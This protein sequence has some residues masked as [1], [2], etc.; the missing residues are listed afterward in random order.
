MA[1]EGWLSESQIRW[2]TPFLRPGVDTD[3]PTPKQLRSS[4]YVSPTR[5]VVMHVDDQG[6]LSSVCR[7][8]QLALPPD[9]VFSHLTAAAIRGWRMPNISTVPIVATTGALAPHHDRR[10]VFVRRCD[11][12]PHHRMTLGGVRVASPEWTIAELAEDLGLVDLVAVIDGALHTGETTVERLFNSIVPGRRG[13]KVLRDS[14]AY[15]DGLS[16][17]WW[18]SV[19][20][21]AHQ[22]A[23]IPIRS[24]V[25]VFNRIGT[26]V[27]RADLHIVGTARYP[28]YEGATHR[29]ALRHR[30]DLS[31]EKRLARMAFERYGY[32]ADELVKTPAM[33]IEDAEDALGW[34]HDTQRLKRWLYELD[35]SSISK[36]GW[37]RLQR[38]LARFG[39][40]KPPRAAQ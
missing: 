39:R 24:Q 5:G 37:I 32:T 13:A 25:E 20:R 16:E 17:S 38:R 18:E 1:V 19:L 9:A 3:G 21:M 6:E 11:L 7:A 33:V 12:S 29:E 28:E 27:A 34:K 15:V 8:I 35:R 4:V 36:P 22:L 30:T 2:M 40:T 23:E 31:R 10:G 26:F 14:L